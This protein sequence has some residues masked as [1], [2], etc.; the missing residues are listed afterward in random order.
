[1]NIVT[2]TAADGLAAPTPD[3]AVYYGLIRQIPWEHYDRRRA[4]IREWDLSDAELLD[5]LGPKRLSD[6]VLM[7][8]VAGTP[9][10]RVVTRDYDSGDFLVLYRV[11]FR[12][13]E[14]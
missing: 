6:G 7:E 1:M 13:V 8:P 2:Y 5:A 9:I 3:G 10:V 12:K 14:P 4:A 11:A